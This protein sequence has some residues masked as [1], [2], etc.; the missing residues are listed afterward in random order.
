MNYKYN[1]R[2]RKRRPGIWSDSKRRY[3]SKTAFAINHFDRWTNYHIDLVLA[4]VIPDS[5]LAELLGRSVAAV[6]KC[7]W[8]WTHAE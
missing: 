5:E 8:T 2:W 6:Q 1:K 3:Y 7:R 4:H